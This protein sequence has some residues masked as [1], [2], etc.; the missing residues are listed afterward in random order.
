VYFRSPILRVVIDTASTIRRWTRWLICSAPCDTDLEQ[1]NVCLA[2]ENH[3]R[4][5]ADQFRE[6]ATRLDS[7]YVGFCWTRSIRS[8]R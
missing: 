2:I 1:A 5:T 6:I 8:A 7:P 3:D 4:F